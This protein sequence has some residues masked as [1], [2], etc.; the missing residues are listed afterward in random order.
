MYVRWPWNRQAY[1][2]YTLR[3][4]NTAQQIQGCFSPALPHKQNG[5][6][7]TGGQLTYRLIDTRRRLLPLEKTPPSSI[8]L[9]VRFRRENTAVEE[10]T[11]H[12]AETRA[13]QEKNSVPFGF[14]LVEGKQGTVPR[15][16]S[17]RETHEVT[18]VLQ[19]QGT[20]K[21]GRLKQRWARASTTLQRSGA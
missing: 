20:K 9:G 16:D 3:G 4:S 2:M 5:Q 13:G 7:R 19:E 17:K 15:P 14:R 21:R 12:A 11:R 1:L 8:K 6:R 10:K 18:H